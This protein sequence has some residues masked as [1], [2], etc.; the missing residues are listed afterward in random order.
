MLKLRL[1]KAMIEELLLIEQEASLL[2]YVAEVAISEFDPEHPLL[3]DDESP[4][5]TIQDRIAHFEIELIASG[6]NP[7]IIDG[8]INE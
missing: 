8:E 1:A 4:L 3:V 7:D 2:A 5:R 6:H